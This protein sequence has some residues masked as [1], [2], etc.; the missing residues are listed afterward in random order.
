MA[1]LGN[2]FGSDSE[3]SSDFLGFLN[4]TGDAGVDYEFT[5]YSFEDG[6]WEVDGSSGSI[7]TDFNLGA[8]LGSMSE[9]E[10]DS[11][12]GGLLGGLLG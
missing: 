1:L 3:S 4:I 11:D 6:E 10:S 2:I 5:D 8:I 9:S 12:G 7:G